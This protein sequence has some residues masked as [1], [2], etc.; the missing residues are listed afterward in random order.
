MHF[1]QQAYSNN[2]KGAAV[3]YCRE[4]AVGYHFSLSLSLSLLLPHYSSSLIKKINLYSNGFRLCVALQKGA[5]SNLIRKDGIHVW[6]RLWAITCSLFIMRRS[7][8]K[9]LSSISKQ[10]KCR[11]I[12]SGI[13]IVFFHLIHLLRQ[14]DGEYNNFRWWSDNARCL[15]LHRSFFERGNKWNFCSSSFIE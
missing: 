14:S 4:K 12:C 8:W 3:I 11:G 2:V 7:P 10:L 5:I 6:K 1:T 15:T 13:L 9:I